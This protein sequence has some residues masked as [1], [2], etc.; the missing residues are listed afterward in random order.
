[1]IQK[2]KE[3]KKKRE[4]KKKK[5]D[6]RKEGLTTMVLTELASSVPSLVK[7]FYSSWFAR[8]IIRLVNSRA[9]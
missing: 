1:M 5:E 3:R 9:S 8:R 4:K 7:L 6:K 2:K